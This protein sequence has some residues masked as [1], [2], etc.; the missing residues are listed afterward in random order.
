MHFRCLGRISYLPGAPF[1]SLLVTS[2]ISFMFVGYRKTDGWRFSFRKFLWDIPPVVILEA[3]VCPILTKKLL[4]PFAI[5]LGSTVTWSFKINYWEFLVH[6][7]LFITSLIIV[8]TLRKFF[9]FVLFGFDRNAFLL[10]SEGNVVCFYT[11]CTLMCYT[12]LDDEVITDRVCYCVLIDAFKPSD[13]HGNRFLYQI[14]TLIKGN[15][16]SYIFLNT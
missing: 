4:S 16:S 13:N 15:D 6:F 12:R 7:F 14:F 8:H 11:V 9:L 10:F 2:L 3:R 5:A 1:W